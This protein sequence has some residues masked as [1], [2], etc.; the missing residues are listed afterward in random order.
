MPKVAKART[1]RT[2]IADVYRRGEKNKLDRHW[3]GFFLDHL[4]ETSNVTAAAHFAGV[5][6]SRAYKVRREDAAFARKWYAALLEGYEHLE[7]ETLRR[8][9]EGVPADGP[10]FDIANA[11]RLLTLHRESV[12]RERAR[13]ENSDEASVLASLNA[14]LE[15]MRQNEMAL[16]E[17]LAEDVTDPVAPTDA[18]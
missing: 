18:G 11:L 2:K 16:Q 4:A 10:K 17:A 7:L 14:K 9:R 1:K 15:A 5:N 13:L 3:R 8:L 6:P 12:A